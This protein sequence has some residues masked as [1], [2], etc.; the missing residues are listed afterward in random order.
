M[1]RASAD[2]SCRGDETPYASVTHC[3]TRDKSDCASEQNRA[4]KLSLC[5]RANMVCEKCFSVH[6]R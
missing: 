1:S 3:V 5:T 6:W 2:D 4:E